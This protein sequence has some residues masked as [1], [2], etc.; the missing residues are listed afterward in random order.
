MIKI[1]HGTIIVGF[2]QIM[3]LLVVVTVDVINCS[4]IKIKWNAFSWDF[5]FYATIFYFINRWSFS[6]LQIATIPVNGCCENCN[7][8]CTCFKPKW[9]IWLYSQWSYYFLSTRIFYFVTIVE[10]YYWNLK[11]INKVMCFFLRIL[12]ICFFHYYT[13]IR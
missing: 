11:G 3:L 5:G 9:L 12:V 8:S 13:H 2:V 4:I 6:F 7:F 10:K 1:V